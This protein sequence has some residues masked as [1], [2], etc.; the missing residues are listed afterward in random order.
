MKAEKVGNKVINAIDE[1]HLVDKGLPKSWICPHCYRKN[2]MGPYKEEELLEFFKT[3]QHCDVC[4]YVHLWTLELTEEFKRK[5][6]EM[7][8]KGGKV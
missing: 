8:T 3:M 5:T 2:I 7:L 1:T 4:G 6:V